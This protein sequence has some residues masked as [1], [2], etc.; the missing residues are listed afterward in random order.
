MGLTLFHSEW[1]KLCGVFGHS[2]CNMVKK[3]IE[4][5]PHNYNQILPLF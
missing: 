5:I 4:K 3:K 2:E 1:P